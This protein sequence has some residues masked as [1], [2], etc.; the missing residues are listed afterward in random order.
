MLHEYSRTALLLGERT[1]DN[2]GNMKVAVFGLGGVGSYAAEALARSGIGVITLVDDDSVSIT[3]IN[4]QLLALHSTVGRQK[5][6]VM[7]ERI[8]D[9]NSDIITNTYDVFYNEE[10]QNLFDLSGFDYIVDC[11]DTVTSKLLLIEN[12]KKAGT[13]IISC[14]GTGNKLDPS[15]FEI[16]DISRTSVCPLAKVMRRELKKRHL[17]KVKVLYSKEVPVKIQDS[18][19]TKG[20]AG[21]P[22]PGSIAFVPGVAGLMIAGEVIRDLVKSMD[23]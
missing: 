7:K 14:M 16:A 6:Q 4:R 8:K 20:S 23:K 19:E 1:V 21:R 11:I 17:K 2:L 3:N 13:A 22:V 12:A 5:T 15:K 18:E 10:T 9:I